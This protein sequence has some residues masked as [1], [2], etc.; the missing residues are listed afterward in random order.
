MN[1]S[2]NLSKIL[3]LYKQQDVDNYIKSLNINNLTEKNIE[4]EKIKENWNFLGGS[5]SNLSSVNILQDGEKGLIERITNA[6]DAVIEK[7]KIKLNLHPQNSS[8]VMKNAFPE[9]WKIINENNITNLY[10]KDA[11]DKVFLIVNDGSKSNKPTFDIID[12]GIGINGNEFKKTIL[13]LQK[14]NK[15]SPDKNYLIGA[16]GQGGSTSL[17]FAKST[18]V[19]SKNNKKF[20][21]TIIK[22]VELSD[23]KFGTY[24]YLAQNNNILE[25]ENDINIDKCNEEWIKKFVTAE[26]GTLVRM[27]ETDISKKY[28]DNEVT[29][30]GQLLSYIDTQLFRVKFPVKIIDNRKNYQNNK[31]SQNRYSYGS[32]LHLLSSKKHVKNKYSGEISIIHNNSQYPFKYFV[33]LP[34]DEKDWGIDWKC[35]NIFEQY[36]ILG[37]PIIYTV[38]GQTINS[39]H[40]TKIQNIGLNFLRYRLLVII[41]LD[42]LGKEKYK[43][44]TS[45]RQNIKNSDMTKNFLDK[46][47]QQLSVNPLLKELNKKIA[48]M[49]ISTSIDQTKLSEIKE[50]VKNQYKKYQINIKKIPSHMTTGHHNSEVEEKN[51]SDTIE[52]LKITSTKT[53]FYRDQS[54]NFILTTNAQ[55]RV[56]REANICMFIDDKHH[57]EV[58]ITWLNGRI[59][60]T[61]M[62]KKIFVGNHKVHFEYFPPHNMTT[63]NKYL[64]SNALTFTILNQL[65][66]DNTKKEYKKDLNLDIQQIDGADLILSVSKD[67]INKK[68]TVYVC[69]NHQM[70]KNNVYLVY[71]ENEISKIKKEILKPIALFGLFYDEQYNKINSTEEKNKLI[72]NIVKSFINIDEQNV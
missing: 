50:K 29:K 41:N 13:S 12:T 69:L 17:P 11:S 61:I 43:F 72:T 24:M 44:I 48:D 31:S 8:E 54:I 35:K 34:T 60:Y 49:M 15:I 16:F 5:D 7:Y 26:S 52:I 3:S 6:I 20:F 25:L 67:K 27:I 55:R 66:P 71:S 63:N 57:N 68:I 51:F 38:N 39:E 40:F 64:V 36:N 42:K 59:S 32:Y 62:P 19:L 47:V 9:Y 22:Y 33:I 56:N 65:S 14:G 28:R 58:D 53:S 23:S 45:N 30:P 70:L 2:I 1:E 46:I 21:F 10:A 37:D 4:R 18:I